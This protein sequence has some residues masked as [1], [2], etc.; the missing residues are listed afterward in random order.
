MDTMNIKFH[1]VADIFPMMGNV[2]F[3]A[4][5]SDIANNGLIEPIWTYQNKIIDGRNRYKACLEAGVEPRFKEWIGEESGLV[6]FVISENLHRRHLDETQ[7][8]MAAA[9]AVEYHKKQARERQA[10]GQTAPGVTLR[11]NLPEASPDNGR[12][13]D[14]A[15]KQFNV[16]GKTVDAA[17]RVLADGTP[18]LIALCDH[19][20]ASV[21]TLAPIVNAPVEVK[22][23]VADLLNTGEAKTTKDAIRKAK[24][25]EVTPPEAMP[26]GKY[27]VIYADPP[28]KYGDG[29]TDNYGGTQYHYPSMSIDELCALPVK[30][31][32]ENDAVLFLWVTSPLLEECFPVIRAWGF[33]YKAS[34]VWD[35]VK[36]NMG[37][38]NS[39][40]HEFL[41]ICT[42]GSCT[43]DEKTLIDSVQSIERTDKHSEKPRE[44]RDIIE[45]LY[46]HG[47][48][49]ELFARHNH[50]GWITY[51]NQL[52]AVS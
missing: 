26:S 25:S 39:V 20:K 32:A 17:A 41:L 11:E 5:K 51:G 38:Y 15:G 4:L 21:T 3:E 40:R 13:R 42:R 8:G 31:L 37:H 24:K 9:R 29:L 14:H 28:W 52:Q 12:A 34:F 46:K 6:A 1:E 18:E 43:P 48:K 30:D 22:R 35:K 33:K 47:A 49:L 19:G 27:R 7:R 36:H 16:S 10:H 23:K 45:T 2:E 50:E 44:F